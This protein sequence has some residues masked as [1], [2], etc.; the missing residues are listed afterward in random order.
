MIRSAIATWNAS[1]TSRS[2]IVPIYRN[3]EN[4]PHL[5]AALD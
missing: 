2:L 4:I 5:G 3:A 1:M